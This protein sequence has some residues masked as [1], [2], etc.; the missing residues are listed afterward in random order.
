MNYDVFMGKRIGIHIAHLNTDIF[1]HSSLRNC[2][3]SVVLDQAAG[4]MGIISD[5][6]HFD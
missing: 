5:Q 1:S 2:S 6:P 3:S 4:S